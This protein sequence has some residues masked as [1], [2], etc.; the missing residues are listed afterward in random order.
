MTTSLRFRM[1]GF[2]ISGLA[3]VLVAFAVAVFEETERSLNTGFNDGIAAAAR[4]VGSSVEREPDGMHVELDDHE[5]PQFWRRHHPDYFEIW[6][7]NGEAVARSSSLGTADLAR[8][9]DATRHLTV[10]RGHLPDGRRGKV[11]YFSFEPRGHRDADTPAGSNVLTLAVARDTTDLDEELGNMARLLVLGTLT[12]VIVSFLLGLFIVRQGLRPLEH[13]ATAIGRIDP[14]NLAARVSAAGAPSELEPVV[15]RLNDLL[16]RIEGAFARER[17]LTADVAHELRTPLAGLRSTIEVALAKPRDAGEYREALSDCAAIVEHAQRLTERLLALARMEGRQTPLT[18]GRVELA[19]VVAAAFLPLS[20]ARTSRR[21]TLSVDVAAPLA[22]RADH[23]LLLH[24][25]SELATNAVEYADQGGRISVSACPL[26][27][28]VTL[29]VANTGCSLTQ[30]QLTHV[31][32]RLWRAD[33][34]RTR[35]GTHCGLGL[36]LVHQSIAAMG[37]T[38]VAGLADGVF[39]VTLTLPLDSGSTSS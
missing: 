36:T 19:P 10:R 8:P 20:D 18:V 30:E 4:T 29:S 27:D 12:T 38:A 5:Y 6:S 16:A 32:D 37:G 22:C 14:G 17:T 11:A 34:S 21:L 3:I 28:T 2:V 24:A 33:A 35:T 1:L 7:S 25:V 39:T 9:T 23:D 15:S 13:V 31:F 26:Q